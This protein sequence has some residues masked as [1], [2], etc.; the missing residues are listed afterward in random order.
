MAELIRIGRLPVKFGAG[1]R[2]GGLE[3]YRGEKRLMDRLARDKKAIY[4]K[5]AKT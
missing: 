1:E 4:S 3:G 2:R 5:K